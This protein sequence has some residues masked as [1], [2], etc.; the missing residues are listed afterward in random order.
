MSPGQDWKTGC[1]GR[2]NRIWPIWNASVFTGSPQGAFMQLQV[3][4]RDYYES[5]E[6]G[7]GNVPSP[8]F[9]GVAW[10]CQPNTFEMFPYHIP[11]WSLTIVP[12]KTHKP[13]FKTCSFL[14][15]RSHPCFPFAFVSFAFA[16]LVTTSISQNKIGLSDSHCACRRWLNSLSCEQSMFRFGEQ[17][18]RL[19]SFDKPA[20]FWKSVHFWISQGSNPSSFHDDARTT[21][22]FSPSVGSSS[23]MFCFSISSQL[24][25]RDIQYRTAQPG[26]RYQN[27]ISQWIYYA[28]TSRTPSVQCKDQTK[29]CWVLWQ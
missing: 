7:F 6:S 16:F 23:L 21:R 18:Y 28:R 25:S 20:R 29:R 8:Y 15:Y 12:N 11:W 17:I 2:E 26:R 13:L 19:I 14:I 5:R 4:L 24:Q 10:T 1:I 27:V 9:C 22:N 3:W